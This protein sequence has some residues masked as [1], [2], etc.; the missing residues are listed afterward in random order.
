MSGLVP[1]PKNLFPA[2]HLSA[3]LTEIF[4]EFIFTIFV[5]RSRSEY[6][7]MF[8]GAGKFYIP[9]VTFVNSELKKTFKS[10]TQRIIYGFL[11]RFLFGFFCLFLAGQNLQYLLIIWLF[12]I[13][14]NLVERIQLN[15]NC[16]VLL[17]LKNRAGAWLW[18]KDRNI[19]Y[20]LLF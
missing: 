15:P 5:E 3:K 6:R 19:F 20:Y 11:E 10:K 14:N 7:L 17:M 4:A 16:K 13:H 8:S 9:V 2:W 18:E 12:T 1:K